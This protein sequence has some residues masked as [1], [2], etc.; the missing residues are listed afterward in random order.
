MTNLNG[1]QLSKEEWEKVNDWESEWW[2]DCTNTFIE[3]T[4]HLKVMKRI[5]LNASVRNAHLWYDLQ[6]KSILDLGGGVVSIL[7]K[8]EN[9]GANCSVVD[10]IL[11]KAPNWV[12]ERY[13]TARI[14]TIGVP[15]EE[16]AFEKVSGVFNEVWLYNVLQHTQDPAKILKGIK[17]L[18][19]I[20][21][22]IHEWL[23]TLPHK[24][25]PQTITKEM[26]DKYLDI[27]LKVANGDP[28]EGYS[29]VGYGVYSI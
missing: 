7:L 1:V 2:S 25:H 13:N 9:R 17:S 5:G 3:E 19:P 18:S 24:G 21:I 23:N 4:K 16:Y 20:T 12:I 10:P 29:F 27:D 8:C 6:G 11:S 26:I 22:R 15:A 14:A 28:S